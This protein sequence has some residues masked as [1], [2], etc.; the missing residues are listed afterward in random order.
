MKS[1]KVILSTM[2]IIALTLPLPAQQ[3]V[4]GTTKAE[5]KKHDMSGKLGKPTLDATVKG[6]HLKA[7]VMTQ[8][9]HT[10][11]MKGMNHG[12]MGMDKAAMD[13]MM[14]GTHHIMLDVT[15]SASG[16]EIAD[17]SAKVLIVS[18]SKK[19][20]AFDLK[21]MMNDFGAGLTLKEKG[22]YRFTVVVRVAG[23]P[24]SK[25]FRYRVK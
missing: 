23:A 25:E 17:A 14:T 8:S 15:D 7:W 9:R 18:P 12:D 16:K 20:S 6:L 1:R 4:R 21:P 22:E 10:K 11:M 13:A 5:M 3:D 24:K 2:L 19:N